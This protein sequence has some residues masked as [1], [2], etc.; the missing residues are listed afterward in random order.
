RRSGS[1]RGAVAPLT[2]ALLMLPVAAL[3]ALLTWNGKFGVAS[4]P[5][6]VIETGVVKR[7]P[8][9]VKVAER[10]NIESANNL[11]LRSLVEGGLGTTILKIV[12]EGAM[13]KPGQIVV[14]LDSAKLRE[15]A[16]AQQI[17]L[18]AAVAALK[19]G[20][21]DVS[22]QIMQNESDVAAAEL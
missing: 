18:D 21:A 8:L 4:K 19:N 12:D 3:G 14:E 1:R 7:G 17:R 2:M 16:L 10:G 11:T 15:E 20:E 22:I 13:V 6:R 9:E 5:Q